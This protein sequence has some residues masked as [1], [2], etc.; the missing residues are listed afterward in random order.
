MKAIFKKVLFCRDYKNNKFY[1]IKKMWVVY[2][3]RPYGYMGFRNDA[4]YFEDKKDAIE[5]IDKQNLLFRQ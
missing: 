2:D 1:F 5:F 3:N 4:Y